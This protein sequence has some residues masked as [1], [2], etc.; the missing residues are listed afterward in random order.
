MDLK[1]FLINIIENKHYKKDIYIKNNVYKFVE[2]YLLKLM[3][4][5]KS[6]SKIYLLYE[7]FIKKIHYLKKFNLDD[8]SLFIEF[9]KKV[10]NG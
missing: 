6:Q 1:N 8:E 4:L 7:N 5:S 9:K 10:L 2:F 3:N